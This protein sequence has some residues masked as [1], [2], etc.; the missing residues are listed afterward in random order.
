[1]RMNNGGSRWTLLAFAFA[2]LPDKGLLEKKM[3]RESGSEAAGP[4]ANKFEMD[5]AQTFL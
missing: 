2:I 4:F 5:D 1:M 3:A